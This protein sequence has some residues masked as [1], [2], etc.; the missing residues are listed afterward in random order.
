MCIVKISRVP[1]TA[2]L[3]KIAVSTFLINQL[4]DPMLNV[5]L[6]KIMRGIIL[7]C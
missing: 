5:L 2:M 1:P 4:V 6:P 3:G 7:F